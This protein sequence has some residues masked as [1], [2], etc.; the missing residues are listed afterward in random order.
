M[1]IFMTMEVEEIL[2]QIDQSIIRE[3][4]KNENIYIDQDRDSDKIWEDL[5]LQLEKEVKDIAVFVESRVDSVDLLKRI[6]EEVILEHLKDNSQ[7][8]IAEDVGELM[9]QI[10][11][12]GCMDEVIELMTIKYDG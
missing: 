6:D 11:V 2:N 7:Y 3:Y 9:E 5:E 1:K 4:V 8:Y 10:R 12:S